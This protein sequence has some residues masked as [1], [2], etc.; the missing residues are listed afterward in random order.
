MSTLAAYRHPAPARKLLT[1]LV[2]VVCPP[3][4]ISL[5]IED[6]I[7]D[8]VELSM[9][10]SPAGV[11][12]ALLTGMTGYELAAALW[13]PHLGRR[14]SRLPRRQAE[15]Y[16]HSWWVSPLPPQREFAKGIKGLLCLGCYE[17]PAMKSRLGYAPEGWI[18]HVKSRRL[19]EY[20]DAIRRHQ[21]ALH[22]PDP[23]PGLERG[24]R[25]VG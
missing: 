7:V 8:H 3:D 9:R 11:R 14:A 12:A 15:R 25:G 19:S 24:E 20:T 1:S 18:A 2:T 23:L 22:A 13:P 6:D 17:H 5:G 21:D 10:A 4:A 16:F